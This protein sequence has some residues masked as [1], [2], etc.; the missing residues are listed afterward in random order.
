MSQPP[1]AERRPHVHTEHGVARPDPYHWLKD[2][3]DPATIAYLEAENAHTEAALAHTAAVRR[4]LYDELLARI[5]EDDASVPV[6]RDG[7]RYYTRTATGKPYA[8]HCRRPILAAGSDGPEQVMLDEN[9]LAE[10]Q[11]YLQVSATTVSPD[12][13]LLAWLQDDDGAERFRLRVRDLET[14]AQL[15]H[16]VTGLKW[17]LAWAQDS[18]TLFYTRA[19]HA[20][21]PCQIWRHD[22]LTPATDDVMVL[23][24]PD[25]LFF[26]GVSRTR[27]RRFVV[28]DIGSKLTS[29]LWVVDAAAP[30]TAPRCVWPRRAG[31]EASLSHGGDRFFFRTNLDA[32]NFRLL[33]APTDQPDALTEVIAHDPAALLRGVDVFAGHLVLWLFRDGLPHLD[34]VRRADGA[35]HAI[36]FP[37]PAYE[38]SGDSNPTYESH[39]YRFGYSSFSQPDATVAY[40]LE[41]Q[42]RTLLKERPVGG[43]FDKSR[44]TTR[45]LWATAPDGER[46][47]VSLVHRADVSGPGPLQLIGYGAYGYSYPVYFSSSRLAL[48]DRGVTLAIAHI[49]G[50]SELGRRWYDQGKQQHKMNTFTDFIAVA[51]HLIAEGWTSPEALTIQGGSAG[52]LLMGAVTNLRPDLFRAVV[53]QVPFVDALSTMFDASLPLTVTE[54]EEWGNPNDRAVFDTMLAYSPY[55]NVVERD[56]WPAMLITGGMNDPRVGFWEPAKWTARLRACW[57][58]T[59]RPLLLRMH[60]G[61]G[62]GGQSGR[63][64]QLEDLSWIYAFLLDQWGL[65]GPT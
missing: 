26:L 39:T 45:R 17:S 24:E 4:A 30:T 19:D 10:G 60:M 49:R 37:E 51:E 62:H 50:G 58:E 36:A 9:A 8:L 54:Y 34:V 13:R 61:A 11:D 32:E 1:A 55:D 5:V 7:F 31:V 57:G 16:E 18:R 28:L 25:E 2:R 59:P 15:P 41:A 38:L 56:N 52:G 6:Q 20:Q 44:Y 53:A 65:L 29:E 22:V 33:S 46:I 3:E 40:D 23:E 27:D 14:G 48:L 21:R 35:R 63:Y 12:H 42:T 64:G 47:P 43:D